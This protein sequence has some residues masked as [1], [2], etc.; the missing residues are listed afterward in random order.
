MTVVMSRNI[1]HA[2]ES[3]KLVH[4]KSMYCLLLLLLLL[5]F[6]GF[7]LHGRKQFEN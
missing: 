4:Y 7:L 3:T 6:N 5:L 2:S 1:F